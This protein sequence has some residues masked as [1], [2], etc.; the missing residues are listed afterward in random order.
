MASNLLVGEGEDGS[1]M[2]QEAKESAT[3]TTTVANGLSFPAIESYLYN[4]NIF[5]LKSVYAI[6]NKV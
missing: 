4:R 3:T 6:K 1:T 5:H 2:S